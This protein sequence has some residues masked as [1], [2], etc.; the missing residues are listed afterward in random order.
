MSALWR[1]AVSCHL[2]MFLPSREAQLPGLWLQRALRPSGETP[3]TPLHKQVPF[4]T[5]TV[6]WRDG[7]RARELGWHGRLCVVE[8]WRASGLR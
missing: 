7:H 3:T 8:T 6:L 1:T 4:S 2:W 5:H